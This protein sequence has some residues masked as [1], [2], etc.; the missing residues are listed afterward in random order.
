MR[1]P[2]AFAIGIVALSAST[3]QAQ[4]TVFTNK[5]L[6]LAALSSFGTQTFDSLPSQP[7]SGQVLSAG[8]FGFTANTSD[9]AFFNAGAGS[10]VWLSTN[11]ATSTITF[12]TFTGAPNAIGGDFFTSNVSGA[13]LA[14]GTV[15]VALDGANTQVVASSSITNFIGFITTTSFSSLTVTAQTVGTTVWPTV[16]N[17]VL[18]KQAAAAAPEPGTIGLVLLGMIGGAAV[19]RR[20]K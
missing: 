4:V 16:N 11:N 5:A 10:D 7:A 9:P 3:A 6:F 8:S 1:F 19:R 14:S 2:L 18:G 20:R 12:N 17:L 13:F 15:T